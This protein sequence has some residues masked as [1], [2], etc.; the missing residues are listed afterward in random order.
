MD[1]EPGNAQVRRNIWGKLRREHKIWATRL[2]ETK[3]YYAIPEVILEELR[4]CK[5]M[6]ISDQEYEGELLF[7]SICAEHSAVGVLGGELVRCGF[8]TRK[9]LGCVKVTE[10]VIKEFGWD[11]YGLTAEKC[12]EN[13]KAIAPYLERINA[14]LAAYSG[15]LLTN[16]VFLKER[17]LLRKTIEDSGI[18]IVFPLKSEIHGHEADFNRELQNFTIKWGLPQHETREARIALLELYKKTIAPEAHNSTAVK[19]TEKIRISDFLARWGLR[20]MVTWDLP[21]PQGPIERGTIA[22][23]VSFVKQPDIVGRML[24]IPYWYKVMG[25]DNILVRLRGEQKAKSAEEY[26]S[27]PPRQPH[28]KNGWPVENDVLFSG[29]FYTQLYR[30]AVGQRW[31]LKKGCPLSGA[32]TRGLTR[33]FKRTS[34]PGVGG[35]DGPIT[36]QDTDKVREYSAAI[37]RLLKGEPPPKRK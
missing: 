37:N 12:N 10:K 31:E 24:F 6:R 32:L 36:A 27:L 25:D 19:A 11:Q 34:S 14:R 21:E 22:D 17:D 33:F 29:I 4:S 18:E 23:I 2:G 1:I 13:L 3:P 35:K 7:T 26:D 30:L 20:Q 15:W 16:P 9:S 28:V 8:I 5:S